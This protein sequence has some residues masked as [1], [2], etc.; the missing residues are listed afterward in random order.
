M[1][2]GGT[3]VTAVGGGAWGPTALTTRQL[4]SRPDMRAMT[5][6]VHRW[7]TYGVMPLG[8]LAGGLGASL[9]GP[10]PA[11]ESLAALAQL[12]IVPL[13]WSPLRTLRTLNL[14]VEGPSGND[15]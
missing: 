5:A 9:L 12:T 15:A 3:F 13:L 10:G 8:A 4:L 6:A 11:I 2:A 14:K 1:I 7:A